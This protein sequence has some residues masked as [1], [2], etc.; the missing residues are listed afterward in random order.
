MAL[1]RPQ[2]MERAS[3]K[4]N[5]KGGV[6]AK[7][8][9]SSKSN[10]FGILAWVF[11]VLWVI[12]YFGPSEGAYPMAKTVFFVSPTLALIFSFLSVKTRKSILNVLSSI[13]SALAII[14]VAFAYY[15]SRYIFD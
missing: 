5:Y 7:V 3:M 13:L 12:Y 15:F 2:Q 10:I 1:R 11:L 8:Q 14:F 9:S 4:K 6:M